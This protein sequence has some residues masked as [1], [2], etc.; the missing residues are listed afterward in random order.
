LGKLI[1]SGMLWKWIW[2]FNRSWWMLVP[3]VIYYHNSHKESKVTVGVKNHPVNGFSSPGFQH[4]PAAAIVVSFLR[5]VPCSTF[6]VFCHQKLWK[7]QQSIKFSW[8]WRFNLYT[9]RRWNRSVNWNHVYLHGIWYRSI[10]SRQ[11]EY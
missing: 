9:L 6:V 8:S 1:V 5:I 7:C 4:E 11:I 3:Q 10:V 2:G